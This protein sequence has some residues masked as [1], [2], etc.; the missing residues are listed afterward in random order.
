M[1]LT[2]DYSRTFN[3]SW[4]STTG[5][6][7]IGLCVTTLACLIYA[8]TQTSPVALWMALMGVVFQLWLLWVIGRQMMAPQPALTVS[9]A[10][11]SFYGWKTSPLPWRDVMDIREESLQGHSQ[12]VVT[13]V[14]APEAAASSSWTLSPVNEKRMPLSVLS[15]QDQAA[16]V[17]AVAAGFAAYGGEA[18][19]R[20][21]HARQEVLKA[22]AVFEGRVTR[23]TPV[24][25]ALYLVLALNVGVWLATIAFG[26]DALKPMPADLLAWGANSASSV[27]EDHEYWRL[28]TATFLHGGLMH[29]ALN[30]LGLWSGGRELNRIYGNAQFLLIYFG[31]A[32]AGSA[33]SLHFSAQQA[34][35]VGASGAVFGVLGALFVALYRHR[36]RL[37]GLNAKNVITGQGVFLVYALVQGFAKDGID[38]A[39]HVGGLLAG[40]LLAWI[41]V[42]KLDDQVSDAR[43][44]GLAATG[45]ALCAAAVAALVVST[46]VPT[47]HH[48]Q[49][50][51]FQAEFTRLLPEFQ[52]AEKNF[53]ADLKAT[54]GGSMTAE[55]FNDA[56]EKTH[57]PA[58]KKIQ[59]ALAPFAVPENDTVGA[60]MRDV[61]HANAL[62][63]QMLQ[64]QVDS[65][66]APAGEIASYAAR[67]KAVGE[68]LRAVTARINERVKAGGKKP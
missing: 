15:K 21:V 59:A 2:G 4:R 58:R 3:A 10:G 57:L 43:R 23:I 33:L 64:L 63:V 36:G 22:A 62:M 27:M 45:G 67:I 25:W 54:R 37:S 20:A 61:Q 19:A 52:T 65:V 13:L 44:R 50:F 11:I 14:P 9:A 6:T 49:I 35:S 40:C 7:V 39:A 17:E 18:V 29:L 38:N 12:V 56:I 16:A 46:P 48:R 26:V 51:R 1:Q 34:V 47:V 32:L 42:D 28:L 60:N 30:M 66:H 53:Q 5:K 55:Q 24:I 41:L 8:L 31:S 68:E